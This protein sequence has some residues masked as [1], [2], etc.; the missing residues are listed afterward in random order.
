M[1][2]SGLPQDRIDI[3]GIFQCQTL[4]VKEV[5]LKE[6]VVVTDGIPHD[7]AIPF[8]Q[9]RHDIVSD[10]QASG[11]AKAAAQ[12]KALGCPIVVVDNDT[13]SCH[14]TD[15]PWFLGREG[16][17]VG[18]ALRQHGVIT[19]AHGGLVVALAGQSVFLLDGNEVDAFWRCLHLE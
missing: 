19:S 1:R 9:R 8:F 12:L 6:A 2:T 18:G 7:K 14:L 13:S 15:H 16:K 4:G 11:A 10:G 17:E 3:H 5:R